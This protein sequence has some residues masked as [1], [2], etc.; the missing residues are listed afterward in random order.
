MTRVE[1]PMSCGSRSR[2]HGSVASSNT[3]ARRANVAPKVTRKRR[4]KGHA[5]AHWLLT[6]IEAQ[7]D[8]YLRELQAALRLERGETLCLQ[9]ICNAC[10]A[11]E[12]TKKSR[13][14]RTGSAHVLKSG[15]N[16]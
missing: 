7:P 16:G 4:P 1:A 12:Y 2:K 3:V 9:T 6:K 11:L 14:L 10:W 8:I 15:S 13:R 5:W